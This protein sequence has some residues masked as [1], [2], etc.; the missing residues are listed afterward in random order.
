[1]QYCRLA[2]KSSSNFSRARSVI[3][4]VFMFS[5]AKASERAGARLVSPAKNRIKWSHFGANYLRPCCVCCR[6]RVSSRAVKVCQNKQI[7]EKIPI[8]ESKQRNVQYKKTGNEQKCCSVIFVSSVS[9]RFG[10]VARFAYAMKKNVKKK[11]FA[12]R[13]LKTK[14]VFS[15]RRLPS[16]SDL[17]K[18]LKWRKIKRPLQLCLWIQAITE[19]EIE[20]QPAKK[21][22]VQLKLDQ[23]SSR[24]ASRRHKPIIDLLFIQNIPKLK[25]CLPPK[26]THSE[27][28]Q[29]NGH[30]YNSRNSK[31]FYFFPARTNIRL[32]DIRFQGPK[33]FTLLNR[34]IQSAVSPSLSLAES[35]LVN[36]ICFLLIFVLLEHFVLLAFYPNYFSTRFRHHII[37]FIVTG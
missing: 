23:N 34:N 33:F 28:I 26:C 32:F 22:T 3:G 16:K 13:A 29:R 37:I 31:T 35:S 19:N 20:I 18:V 14:Q 11:N 8:R 4:R 36:I 21:Y 27:C 17:S 6:V 15:H 12:L 2:Y 25:T 10:L 9:R 30:S 24:H 7:T 1:M 5:A